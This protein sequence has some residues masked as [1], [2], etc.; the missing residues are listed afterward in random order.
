MFRPREVVYGFVVGFGFITPKPKYLISLY[1]DD[2][3]NIVA[4]FTTSRHRAGVPIELV[5]H[6]AIIEDGKYL[7][8]V[9]EQGVIVGSHPE[10][11][12]E[13]AFPQR[14][15]VTFDYGIIEGQQEDLSDGIENAELKCV[16]NDTEYIDLVYAMYKSD[17][18]NKAYKPYLEKVLTDFYTNK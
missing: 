8:Y 18:T 12:A 7:S 6:G 15:T 5:H 3:L 9:F 2:N 10:T 16:L 13:F 17:K 14:S 4:C 11:G 1:C